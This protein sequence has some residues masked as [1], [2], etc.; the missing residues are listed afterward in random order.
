M[1]AALLSLTLI[2]F[3]LSCLAQ[4]ASSGAIRGMVF[5]PAGRRIIGASIALVNDATGLRYEQTSDMQGRFAFGLLPAGE[6]PARVTSDKMS[7]QVSEGVHVDIGSAIQITFRLAIAGMS[8]SVTVSA[9]PRSVDTQPRGLS[10]IVDEHAILNLPLN[11]RR[12]TDLCLL[13]PGA[14]EDPRGQN[15][16]SNGDL[17]FGGVRGLPHQLS[18][19]WGGQ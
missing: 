4:D 7:P 10:A 18:G 3:S 16:T 1:R 6:Y 8:E 11:G 13:T 14:T 19:G 17:S 15:S 9:E 12:F 2:T 5:D